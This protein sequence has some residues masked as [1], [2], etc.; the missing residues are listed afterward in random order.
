MK[1][2]NLKGLEMDCYTEVLD[3][4]LEVYMLPY[5]N[6]KNYFISYATRF[7][8]DVLEFTDEKKKAHK[9]PLGIAHFLEHKMFEQEDGQDPF[10]FFSESGTDSNA[11]TSFDNTQYIC[12]GTK[13]FKKNLEYLL[14]FVNRPYYTDENVE[15]EKGIIAEEIKMYED[16]PDFKLETKLRECLYKNHPR[17]ID[18]AGTIEEINKITKEDL[19]SCYENFYVPNN[20][21]ILIVG[22]FPPKEALAIIERELDTKEKKKLPTISKVTEPVKVECKE[23]QLKENIEIPKVALGIKVPTKNIK[24]EKLELD[25]YLNMLTTILFGSSS[26][27]REKAR[28]EKL[29]SGLYME[30]EMLEE[31]HTFY[32]MTSTTQS[33]ELIKEVEKEWKNMEVTEE[34]FSRI[35]KVWIANEVRMID[36]IDSTVNNLYDDILKFGGIIPDKIEKIKNMKFKKLKDL[37][38]EIDGTNMSIVQ[39]IP[40]SK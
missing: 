14:Q 16:V 27:F 39:M 32:M 35:Q 30:W 17:R 33:K 20:M 9:L 4:G 12:Y 24:L 37:M 40:N 29:L 8:S 34:D 38:K 23:C 36:N 3:N 11:S 22:N 1:K 13:E 25:L 5:S 6:K 2:I 31:Y 19:Y 18:I 7:G 21:F 10:T 26:A 15:K 28:Q